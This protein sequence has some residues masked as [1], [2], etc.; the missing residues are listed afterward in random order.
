MRLEIIK[1]AMREKVVKFVMCQLCD[2]ALPSVSRK[3][4]KEVS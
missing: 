4:S 1:G 3:G 2:E